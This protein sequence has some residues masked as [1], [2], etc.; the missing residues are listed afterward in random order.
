MITDQWPMTMVCEQIRTT[1]FLK[2]LKIRI[3]GSEKAIVSYLKL[4]RALGIRV[5]PWALDSLDPRA[6]WA[7]LHY[8]LSAHGFRLSIPTPFESHNWLSR[9]RGDRNRVEPRQSGRS[10]LFGSIRNYIRFNCLE[11]VLDCSAVQPI[12]CFPAISV[13]IY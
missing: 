6:H 3:N 8:R 1:F 7:M 2:T 4:S 13:I 10:G 12:E 9:R 11:Y 5:R